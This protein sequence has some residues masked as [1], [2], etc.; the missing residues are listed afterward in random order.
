MSRK[1]NNQ[2][3]IKNRNKGVKENDNRFE[4]ADKERKDDQ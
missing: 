1:R 4:S 3:A 2:R